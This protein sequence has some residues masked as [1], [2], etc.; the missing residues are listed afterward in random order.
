[1]TDLNPNM[2]PVHGMQ[3]PPGYTFLP[4]MLVPPS[5]SAAPGPPHPMAIAEDASARLMM[6]VEV[7]MRCARSTLPREA[8]GLQSSC[9][10]ASALPQPVCHE[11]KA[12]LF[13]MPNAC[14]LA[15]FQLR[16]VFEVCIPGDLVVEGCASRPEQPVIRFLSVYYA[17]IPHLWGSR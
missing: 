8:P 2:Y 7:R 10:L 11:P 1:M 14:T 9:F 3:L 4:V 12:L 15:P 16:L 17:R 6:L 13:F 5:S